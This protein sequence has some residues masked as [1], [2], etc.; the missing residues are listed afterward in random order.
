MFFVF[1]MFADFCGSQYVHV[2]IPCIVR[3]SPHFT[4]RG[5]LGALTVYGTFTY[6]CT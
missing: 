6:G 5:V 3:I 1:S 2:N 4:K